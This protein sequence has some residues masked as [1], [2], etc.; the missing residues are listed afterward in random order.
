MLEAIGKEGKFKE[1]IAKAK[2]LTIFIYA[3]QRT[4]ALMRKFTKCKDIVRPG[5][6]RYL[7]DDLWKYNTNSAKM[8]I[9]ILSLTIS[10]S[11]CERNWSAFERIN[12]KLINKWARVKNQNIDVLRS[13]DA[14]KAQSW[15]VAISDDEEIEEVGS[16]GVG[17]D[18]IGVDRELHEDDFVS[19]EEQ[20][21]G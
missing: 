5:V 9:K 10:S 1:W 4:L 18:A 16:L 21:E 7:V 17:G 20:V 15:I 8:A 19:D 12:A 11:S 6:T 14:S 13:L 2:T 3:H